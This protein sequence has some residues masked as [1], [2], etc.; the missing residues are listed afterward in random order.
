MGRRE[1]ADASASRVPGFPGVASMVATRVALVDRRGVT[2]GA[3]LIPVLAV[4]SVMQLAAGPG[5][6]R[7][8]RSSYL[9]VPRS[10]EGVQDRALTRYP[11]CSAHA[12][13]RNG[14]EREQRGDGETGVSPDLTS[15]ALA[16]GFRMDGRHNA[17]VQSGWRFGSRKR[18][19]R[20]PSRH[21]STWGHRCIVHFCERYGQFV[22]D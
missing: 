9:S 10:D 5:P 11:P 4:I 12:C 20:M 7:P 17:V 8:L 18:I 19:Y 13:M 1:W 14:D 3:R 2:R 21:P 15:L 16:C 6:G 22:H